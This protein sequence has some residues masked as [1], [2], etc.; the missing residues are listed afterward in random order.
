MHFLRYKEDEFPVDKIPDIC[1]RCRTAI[2]PVKHTAFALIEES[3]MMHLQVV[4]ECPRCMELFLANYWS[5]GGPYV[6]G[7]SEPTEYEKHSFGSIDQ[8]SAQFVEI[9]NQAAEAESSG[10]KEI[11]G[12]GYRKL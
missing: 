8:L 2:R 10:L 9:F 4:Y 3:Q 5:Q 12:L 7:S 1:P 6:L 11:S